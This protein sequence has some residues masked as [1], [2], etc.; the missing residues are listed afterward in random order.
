LKR[1][2]NGSGAECI[3]GSPTVTTITGQMAGEAA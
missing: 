2:A 3:L 1:T